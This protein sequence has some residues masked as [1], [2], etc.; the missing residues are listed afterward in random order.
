M[1]MIRIIILMIKIIF[2][3]EEYDYKDMEDIIILK[4][5]PIIM[6]IMI[7]KISD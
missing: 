4:S 2:K 7:M 5:L 6:K 3:D 1:L